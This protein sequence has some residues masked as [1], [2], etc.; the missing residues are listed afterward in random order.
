MTDRSQYIHSL[1]REVALRGDVQLM[2]VRE[3]AFHSEMLM[4]GAFRALRQRAS[5]QVVR[6]PPKRV[7]RG[8]KR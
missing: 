4:Q 7:V 3:P 1:C 2:M 6:E 5:I 8:K